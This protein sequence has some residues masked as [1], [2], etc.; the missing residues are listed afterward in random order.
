MGSD[1]LTSRT[2][3]GFR[4]AATASHNLAGRSDANARYAGADFHGWLAEMIGDLRFTTVLDI[5]CGTGNQLVLYAGTPGVNSIVGIDLSG[6]SLATARRRV[7]A[8]GY[9]DRIELEAI[10]MEDAFTRPPVAGRSFDLISCCYG[11]YYAR[12][13]ASMLDSM[14]Q[15]TAAGGA[16]LIVGPWG[17]NNADLFR[18]LQRHVTLPELVLRS[19]T[20]FMEQEVLPD[21]RARAHVS[22]RTFV[23]PVTFPSAQSVMDYWRQT[24]FFDPDGESAVQ[25]DLDAH[26]A[27]EDA[28]VVEKH[29]MACIARPR[30]NT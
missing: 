30:E 23:N 3:A 13:V 26:F 2:D 9:Q 20:T 12:D 10:A 29:A 6:E 25:R 17:A 19:A 15:R 16:V 28:F 27:R 18:L 11:L 7:A 1:R 21:L 24:T 22:T 8:A 4:D 5:C 14:L